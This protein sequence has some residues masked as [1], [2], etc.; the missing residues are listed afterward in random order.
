MDDRILAFYD[1]SREMGLGENPGHY[2]T[3]RIDKVQGNPKGLRVTIEEFDGGLRWDGMAVYV[4]DAATFL[5]PVVEWLNGGAEP[6][7]KTDADR[8]AA[9]VIAEARKMHSEHG[10]SWNAIS[11]RRILRVLGVEPEDG[12]VE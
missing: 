6:S 2:A 9:A 10:Q 7:G 12:G 4:P 1:E 11:G 5:A 8:L 3:L